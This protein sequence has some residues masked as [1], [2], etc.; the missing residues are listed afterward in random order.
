MTFMKK[1]YVALALLSI[2]SIGNAYA[3]YRSYSP[4]CESIEEC[5]SCQPCG[6]G[7]GFISAGLIYWRAYEGG[8][9]TCSG[10]ETTDVVANERVIS[11]FSGRS[12]DP[13]FNWNPGF[14]I[15]A[16]YQ[17][18]CSNWGFGADW[19]HFHSHE[20]GSNHV[21]WD[22]NYDEIDLVV[23]YDYE[24]GRCF[25]LV[26]YAGLRA[27]RIDQKVRSG[28]FHSSSSSSFSLS[29]SDLITF[30]HHKQKFSGLGPVL[31][32]EGVWDIGCGFS[33]YANGSVSW[34]YGK[35]N[36]RFIDDEEFA[37][38]E[39]HCKLRKHLDAVVTAADAGFGVR[40]K[41]CFCGNMELYLQLGFEHHIYYEYNRI[42]CCG[43]LSLDGLNF[44][45]A[46]GF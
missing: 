39:N 10:V 42:G 37:L 11:T 34:L 41:T 45:A 9:N 28:D 4:S 33:A 6:C 25:K 32:V 29:S 5:N 30:H 16:G 8:L 20:R 43:D 46:I 26:P 1:I 44:T 23:G 24:L 21:R 18:A 36:I 31:G 38:G 3:D 12:R 35:F 22:L 17:L 27:A 19:T 2:T 7:Q 14:R 13:D 40:W 15:A